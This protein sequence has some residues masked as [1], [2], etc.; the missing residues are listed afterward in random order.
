[1]ALSRVAEVPS[2]VVSAGRAAAPLPV[3]PVLHHPHALR[4]Q[5]A[6]PLPTAADACPPAAPQQQQYEVLEVMPEDE[7]QVRGAAGAMRA[8]SG[9]GGRTRARPR[10]AGGAAPRPPARPPAA[11]RHRPQ[12]LKLRM[13]NRGFHRPPGTGCLVFG[14][15]DDDVRTRL[16][17]ASPVAAARDWLHIFAAAS[18][19]ES[20]S[21]RTLMRE[22]SLSNAAN[23]P[24]AGADAGSLPLVVAA[25][26]RG[27]AAGAAAGAP[28][29]EP[30]ASAVVHL[31]VHKSARVAWR[32]M[33]GDTFELSISSAGGST[34]DLMR[35]VEDATGLS[36]KD[37]Q[38]K[39]VY[40]SQ[41]LDAGRPLASYGIRKG[42]LL[43]LLPVEPPPPASPPAAGRS[44]GSGGARGEGAGAEEKM[45][46]GSPRLASPLH[47]LHDHWQRAR[48]GLLEGHAPRLAPAGTGAAPRAPLGLLGLSLRG[49]RRAAAAVA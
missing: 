30:P 13:L 6:V 42:A 17:Q 25:P 27:G 26:R 31:L 43:R 18:A 7:I 1:M 3:A 37:G 11:A 48:A 22:F 23:E 40:G 33:A 29:A 12:D 24:P 5:L 45:P 14:D 36:L 28:H 47:S 21:V 20:V 46:D 41:V 8:S 4:L 15:L 39:L 38:H 44:A 35:R 2:H 34:N 49:S 9:S 19:V 10:R 16:V 32:H